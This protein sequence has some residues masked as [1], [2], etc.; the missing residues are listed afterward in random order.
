MGGVFVWPITASDMFVK[1]LGER[2]ERALI[3]FVH[4]VALF[5][6]V[7]EFWWSRGSAMWE[8]RRVEGWLG[9]EWL[10]WVEW[11]KRRIEGGDVGRKIGMR[12]RGGSRGSVNAEGI[13]GGLLGVEDGVAGETERGE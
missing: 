5:S 1:L 2:R 3:V 11:P 13:M 7:D 12:E 10:R 6:L 4:Y 8:L 9:P